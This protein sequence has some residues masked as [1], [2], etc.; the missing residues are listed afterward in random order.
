MNTTGYLSSANGSSPEETDV[1][2]STETTSSSSSSGKWQQNWAEHITGNV[3]WMLF[4]VGTVG[5]LVVLVV[6]AWRRSK[7]QVGTQM[8]V[9]SLALAD[10]GLMMTSTW[11][12]AYDSVAQSNRQH[13][14]R[15]KILA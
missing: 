10:I 3:Q 11:V 13:V 7:Q 12:E 1:W 8:F 9:G 14:Q 15:D 2:N 5:N 6:L 4:A